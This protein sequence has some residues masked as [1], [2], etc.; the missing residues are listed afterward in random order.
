M[1]ELISECKKGIKINLIP[2]LILQ[3][4]AITL[5]LLYYNSESV[6]NACNNLA[7]FKT[8]H[9]YL[10]SAVS[11]SIF[12]G[13]LPWLFLSFRG[14]ISKQQRL[15]H[16]I[17][18]TLFWFYKGIE[19]DFLYR[20]QAEM[21]GNEV[22]FPTIVKKVAFDQFVYNLFYACASITICYMWKDSGFS[23]RKTKEQINRRTFTFTLPSVIVS[24][25]VI[26]LPTTAIV[27]SLPS[28]LQI[29][30]FNIVLCF[31]V[32]LVTTL[33]EKKEEA[34]S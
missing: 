24:T 16:G 2:G 19:V 11:T 3:T 32:L 10:F 13:V 6:K 34:I 17:F 18:F 1:T 29:P 28:P 12:G 7:D 27:Y 31:F 15:T 5:V 26:W 8:E 25:W 33:C 14:T 9:G 23:L 30:L 4:F 22:N 20:M 21:F